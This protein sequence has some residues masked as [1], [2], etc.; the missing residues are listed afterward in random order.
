[1]GTETILQLPQIVGGASGNEQLECVASDGVT[2]ARM[3]S[4]M[5]AALGG[6]AGP[7][8]PTGPVGPTGPS[9]ITTG[10]F[11]PTWVGFSVAPAASSITYDISGNLVTLYMPVAT[12]GTSNSI[13]FQLSGLPSA[14]QPSAQR[15]VAVVGLQ[16]NGSGLAGGMATITSGTVTFSTDGTG[17]SWT[18]TGSKGFSFG[19]AIIYPL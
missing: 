18:N 4:G 2:S 6:P 17:G 8:G 5:I 10:S 7:T 3:T 13:S 12:L 15:A 1:M 9:G 19:S 16:N 11:A 14:I